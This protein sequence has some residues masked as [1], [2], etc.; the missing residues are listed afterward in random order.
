VS[1]FTSGIENKHYVEPVTE[2][3]RYALTMGFTCDRS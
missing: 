3:V 1:A 2:G